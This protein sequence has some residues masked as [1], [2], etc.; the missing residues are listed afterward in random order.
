MTRVLCGNERCKNNR[1]GA[2]CITNVIKMGLMGTQ[3]D[4]DVVCVTDTWPRSQSSTQRVN[5]DE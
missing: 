4:Y 2:V 5:E 1:R 3:E